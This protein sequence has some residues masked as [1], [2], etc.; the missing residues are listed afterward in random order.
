MQAQSSSEARLSALLNAPKERWVALSSD[1]STIIAEGATF[2]E[3]A[4]RAEKS[5]ESDP[6]IMFVPEDWTPRV[7]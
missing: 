1:E 4:E 3:V 5:G 2:N 6:L 7:L